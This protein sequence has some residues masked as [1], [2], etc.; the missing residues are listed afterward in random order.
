[1]SWPASD[2]A[3]YAAKDGAWAS[4]ATVYQPL[5]SDLTTF[6]GLACTEGQIP[7]K[8]SSS[9]WVCGSDVEGAGG[10]IS[11]AT[12]DGNYYASRNG[13]WASLTGL[14]QPVDSDLTSIA[15]LTTTAFGIGLL[16]DANAAAGRTSLG[17]GTTDS[18]A[19]TGLSLGIAN[20]A[21]GTL[22]FYGNSK[23]YPFS[24]WSDGADT[25]SLGWKLPSTLP[26]TASLISSSTLGYLSYVDPATFLTPSGVGGA[27]TV[28]ATGF[29]GNLATT[30]NTLQEIAQKFD[31]FTGGGG[32]SLSTANTWT[33]TQSFA[34][35]NAGAAGFAV[36][37]DGDVTAKSVTIARTTSP[38]A[39]R[40]YEGTGGGDNYI[41]LT[42]SGNLAVDST[43]NLDAILTTSSFDDTPDS[44]ST[45]TAPTS[46]WA[47]NHVAAADPHAGYVLESA[48]G[49]DVGAFLGTPSSANLATAVT[50]ET[51]SGALVFGTSPTFTTPIIADGSTLT[52]D[53]SATDPNDADVALSAIDGVFKIAAV[54]GANNEDL[55]IDLDADANIASVKTSTSVSAIRFDMA[56]Q[57]STVF[58]S[59]TSAQTL[60]AAAHNGTIVQM[61]TADEVTMW[62]CG[63]ANIGQFV[64]LWARDAEKIEVVPASGDQFYLFNGTGIGANDELD[65][66][67]TAGTKVTL[68]CTAAD[69]WSVIYETATTTDGGAAD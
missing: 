15:S 13:A 6:S 4:L 42:L 44:G 29:D 60:T 46:N 20:S 66:P 33:A 65:V 61:T 34:Q 2:G 69:T 56:I 31:D 38:T 51:G 16:D 54:N 45:T 41:D 32:V 3:Y 49:A 8:N 68:M 27:L 24:L 67:A 28:T 59:Y 39:I 19:F 17:V 11:H 7:K 52:F 10:G 18:P 48:L 47:Y 40:F 1:M 55:T 64:I 35:I 43:V 22:G 62:N 26:A 58:N 37:A 53:E 23:T 5:D 9:V 12:S 57:S 14:Y 21:F 30:D 63:A 25:G 50:G 36:D